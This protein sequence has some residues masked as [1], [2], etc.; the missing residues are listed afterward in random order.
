MLML[1][2][3]CLA[4]LRVRAE[5]QNRVEG[6]TILIVEDHVV[7]AADLADAVQRSGGQVLGPVSRLS[8]ALAV[9][10]TAPCD[11]ALL[12]IN[13][14]HE[15]SYLAAQMLQVREVPFAFLT[16]SDGDEIESG[17]AKIPVLRKPFSEIEIESCLRR[18]MG[19][20]GIPAPLD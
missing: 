18:L 16:G 2:G 12:D 20:S 10:A 6:F 5:H 4:N 17:Y 13:L 14:G 1:D 8:E 19:S 3:N 7:I 11:A 15:T 9:I